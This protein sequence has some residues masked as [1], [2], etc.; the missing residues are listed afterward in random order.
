[1]KYVDHPWRPFWP[2]SLA[3]AHTSVHKQEESATLGSLS[4]GYS[5]LKINAASTAAAA[6]AAAAASRVAAAS[7]PAV[8][9]LRYAGQHPQTSPVVRTS[10]PELPAQ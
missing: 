5:Q 6:A 3:G 9:S 10:Q 4:H 1:M 2:G 7:P 8:A